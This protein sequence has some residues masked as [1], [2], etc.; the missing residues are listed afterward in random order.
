M[1]TSFVEDVVRGELVDLAT[2]GA[3]GLEGIL[4]PKADVGVGKIG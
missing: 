3:K 2:V 4:M 1:A